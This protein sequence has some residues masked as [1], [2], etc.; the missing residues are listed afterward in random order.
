LL[1]QALGEQQVRGD[2]SEFVIVRH[3]D[4]NSNLRTHMHR[5]IRKAGLEPWPKLFHN[6]RSSRQTELA[7]VYPIKDVC[8]WLGNSPVVAMKHYRQESDENFA[9]AAGMNADEKAS[10]NSAHQ[11]ATDLDKAEKTETTVAAGAAN[12]GGG[13]TYV[14]DQYPRQD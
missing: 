13:D 4:R 11:T 3:R 6:L 5:I 9:K 1:E 2:Q 10:Q 8:A 12:S 7:A 14:S